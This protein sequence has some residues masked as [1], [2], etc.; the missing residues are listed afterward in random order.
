MIRP[1]SASFQAP[2]PLQH[3]ETPVHIAAWHGYDLLL[4]LLCSFRPPLQL[5]N[6]VRRA[7]AAAKVGG[8]ATNRA[9]KK[10]E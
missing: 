10:S 2:P 9:N 4:K 8:G 5:Q 7:A 1:S 3:G 6:E